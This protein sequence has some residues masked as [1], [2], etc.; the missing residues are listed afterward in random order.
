MDC[1]NCMMDYKKEKR[2]KIGSVWVR[3]NKPGRSGEKK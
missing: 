3:K 1:T 2:Y